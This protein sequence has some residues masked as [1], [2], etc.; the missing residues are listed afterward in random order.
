[1]KGANQN[2]SEAPEKTEMVLLIFM[3]KSV[4][5][6]SLL[7]PPR[8]AE[9]SFLGGGG[10]ISPPPLNKTS[11]N[12]TNSAYPHLKCCQFLFCKTLGSS[13]LGATS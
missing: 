9:T 5:R 2:N 4:E 6:G 11:I 7:D 10:S 12:K 13:Q 1:M 8:D 3:Q